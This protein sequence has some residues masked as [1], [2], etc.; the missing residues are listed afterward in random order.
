MTIERCRCNG[1][2]QFRNQRQDVGE[3]V[4]RDGALDHLERDVATESIGRRH[5]YPRSGALARR[6][7]ENDDEIVL[8][9]PAELRLGLLSEKVRVDRLTAQQ[10]DFQLP[11]PAVVFEI[12]ELALQGRDLALVI[13]PGLEAALAIDGMPDEKAADGAGNAIEQERIE[14][15]AKT[16]ANNHCDT[17]ADPG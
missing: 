13:F 7:I 14:N 6:M 16:P 3:E 1:R 10:I 9:H 4:S 15:G 11:A 8:P 12:R 17:V 2:P 5:R